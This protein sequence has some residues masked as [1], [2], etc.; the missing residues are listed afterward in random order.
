MK[1]APPDVPLLIRQIAERCLA[2]IDDRLPDID[3]AIF[4]VAPVLAEDPTLAAESRASNR[5]NVVRC[6][7]AIQRR[8]GEPI[9][10][11][12]PLETLDLA[13]TLVRRGI[14][15]E[16]LVQSYRRGM[17]AAWRQWMDVAAATVVSRG[18]LVE[19]L[20]V[21]SALLF[22]Y[23]D[24]ALDAVIT[25][26]RQE[27]RELLSGEPALRAETIRLLLDGAPLN[28]DR[29]GRRLDYDLTARHTAAVLWIDP[30]GETHGVLEQTAGL[31]AAAVHARRPLTLPAGTSTL[32]AWIATRHDPDWQALREAMTHA[33]PHVRVALGPPR[34][35][36]TGFRRS[37]AAALSAQRLL[38]GNP[39]GERLVPYHEVEAVALAGRDEEQMKEF[40]RSAL[41]PLCGTEP[42]LVTL[43]STLR[44]YLDE[45]GNAP[46][47]AERLHTHRNTV[48][49]RVARAE[50]L[51]G[52]RVAERRLAVSLALEL[53]HRL[54]NRALGP[55][56]RL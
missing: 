5:A 24:G 42:A 39:D 31:L 35:G 22:D 26:I 21:T 25:R 18:D 45:G 17:N 12:A 29:A 43:R 48:L 44:V 15:L 2:E 3:A 49:H 34:T 50:A 32:W 20:Q 19:L 14:E 9:P 6:L 30:P 10:R 13:R 4:E 7:T 55:A 38:A 37:H 28:T 47:T 46:R 53:L 40:I 36:V 23:A 33:T 41:G 11:G 54:G 1:T 8:P 16:V 27:R 51:L 56:E 52:F